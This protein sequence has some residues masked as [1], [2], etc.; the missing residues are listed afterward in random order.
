MGCLFALFAGFFPRLAALFLWLARPALFAAAFGGNWLWPV[1]G[2]IFLP[3]TT[4]LYVVLW[5]PGVG[6]AGLDWV[7]LG[8]ALLMDLG[9]FGST[10]YA[11]RDRLPRYRRA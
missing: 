8:L 4:L 5:S 6:F 1:L 10:G 3:F 7:W 9:G 11:N 2:L